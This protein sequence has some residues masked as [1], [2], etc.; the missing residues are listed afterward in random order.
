MNTAS[1]QPSAEA[2]CE[3]RT[4][5]RSRSVS[6]TRWI[7]IC[8]AVWI[9][10]G[11]GGFFVPVGWLHVLPEHEATR[12]PPLRA[13]FQPNLAITYYP[14]IGETA[15]KGN[16]PPTEKR[17]P[18]KFSTDP[19]GFRLTPGV[20]YQ[21]HVDFLL[22]E[23]ASFAYGGGLSDDETLP[24][25]FTRATG[26]KMYNGGRYFWDLQTIDELDWLLARL[27]NRHPAVVLLYWEQFEHTRSQ[28]DGLPWP[29]DRVLE[30]LIGKRGNETFR[31]ALKSGRRELAAFT[32]ISPI[33]VLS[34]RFFKLLSNDRV[35]PNRYRSTIEERTLPD[36]APFLLL[37]QEVQRVLHPPGQETVLRHGDY[38]DHYRQILAARGCD[39]YVVLIPNKYS[40]YGPLIDGAKASPPAPY[41]D[42][43]EAGLKRRHIHVVNGLS[44]LKP[45]AAADLASG[46]LSFFRE[47]HHWSLR[48]VERISAALANEV[49]S[50]RSQEQVAANALQ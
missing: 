37:D 9:C 28:L 12:R 38:F 35:L 19:L 10:A 16:L 23:G 27:G 2:T 7:V 48:G 17:P 6:I 1:M 46:H 50:V 21:D 42:R 29:T 20:S 30:K 18:L 39:M 24:V 15:L 32:S 31:D 3:T 13:P 34:I 49:R 22:A 45:F 41:L 26:L 14:W 8:L 11:I 5:Q 33:E 43:L 36:G 4:E 47:D 44:V 40:L 25:V